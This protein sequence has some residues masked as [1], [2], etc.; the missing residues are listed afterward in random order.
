MNPV[1]STGEGQQQFVIV[2]RGYCFDSWVRSLIDGQGSLS[3]VS[4]RLFELPA[5]DLAFVSDRPTREHFD[6]PLMAVAETVFVFVGV[7]AVIPYA[8]ALA[9]RFVRVVRQQRTRA[10]TA[11]FALGYSCPTGQ[12][13][14]LALMA[15]A[16]AVFVFVRVTAVIAHAVA[17]A[18]RFI[19][20][21]RQRW[22]CIRRATVGTGIRTCIRRAAAGAEIRP[23]GWV[24]QH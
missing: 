14:G 11:I 23:A 4:I 7:A 8:V 15:V 16:K 13:L 6:C 12:Y 21:A 10:R 19:S 18:L 17:L 1:L 9:L 22:A 24:S 3:P 2:C 5:V 20:V